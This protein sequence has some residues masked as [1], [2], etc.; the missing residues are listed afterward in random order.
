MIS[1]KV[2]HTRKKLWYNRGAID[3]MILL[4]PSRKAA[5]VPFCNSRH[6]WLKFRIV[7]QSKHIHIAELNTVKPRLSQ[8]LP[9]EC[10]P[11]IA[12]TEGL[13]LLHYQPD[14]LVVGGYASTSSFAR[15][16]CLSQI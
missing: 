3:A 10:L 8:H 2:V 11:F 14:P 13:P 6:L 5:I 7:I 16:R 4:I 15:V 12:R 9:I 1:R